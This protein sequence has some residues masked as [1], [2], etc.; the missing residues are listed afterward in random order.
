MTEANEKTVQ[1]GTFTWSKLGGWMLV[2]YVGGLIGY[3]VKG[4]R[5]APFENIWQVLAVALL[6]AIPFVLL[7]VPFFVCLA[8]KLFKISKCGGFAQTLAI[9]YV[10]IT[11]FQ[12]ISPKPL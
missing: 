7:A 5:Q 6:P 8:I 10:V 11:F 9:V 3:F 4:V 2:L 1:T 12:I